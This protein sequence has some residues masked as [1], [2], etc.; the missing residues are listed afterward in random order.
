MGKTVRSFVEK[1]DGGYSKTRSNMKKL[2]RQMERHRAKQNP[3][4]VPTYGRYCG[5]IS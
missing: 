4:V 5:W 2:K 3:E 1:A